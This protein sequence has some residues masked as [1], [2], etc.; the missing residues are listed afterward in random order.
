[1][2]LRAT[3]ALFAA[4]ITLLVTGPVALTISDALLEGRSVTLVQVLGLNSQV[5]V[6]FAFIGFT[7][8][9]LIASLA[10][11]VVLLPLH[12][13]LDAGG[14]TGLGMYAAVGYAAGGLLA[15]LIAAIT[16]SDAYPQVTLIIAGATAGA[17]SAGVFWLVRRP[18]WD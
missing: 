1:M 12:M 15:V 6:L 5:S 14:H 9:A 13:L 18:D 7:L 11:L 2:A 17:L 16:R 10:L 4:A 8:G 3:L